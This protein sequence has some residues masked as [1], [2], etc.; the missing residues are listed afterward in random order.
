MNRGKGRAIQ[1]RTSRAIESHLQTVGWISRQ[2]ISRLPAEGEAFLLTSLFIKPP[3]SE[4]DDLALVVK[5]GLLLELES[6]SELHYS[7]AS[8]S[9]TRIA[10]RDIWGLS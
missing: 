6:R 7:R 9:E 4:C 8:A 2:K 5:R 3:I 1:R 10:L